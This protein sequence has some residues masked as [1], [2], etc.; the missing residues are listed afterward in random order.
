MSKLTKI[1]LPFFLLITVSTGC[2]SNE[3]ITVVPYVLLLKP[4]E[5][6]VPTSMKS[7]FNELDSMLPEEM[8]N[9][10]SKAYIK[11]G[12]TKLKSNEYFSEKYLF[13]LID[14]ISKFSPTEDGTYLEFRHELV[15]IWKL[16]KKGDFTKKFD[17]KNID[18][19]SIVSIVIQAYGAHL[20]S[21]VV[22]VDKLI[23]EELK[24]DENW[25]AW[26]KEN[27]E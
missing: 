15:T 22:D 13:C 1:I 26:K 12:D 25:K 17:K 6:F 3:R 27:I 20:N 9:A 5:G 4:T 21:K 14:E 11:A 19:Q 24:K 2:Y 23:E 16:D 8:K 10:M 18:E 7:V